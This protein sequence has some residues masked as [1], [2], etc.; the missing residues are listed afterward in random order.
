MLSFNPSAGFHQINNSIRDFITNIDPICQTPQSKITNLFH[1][2]WIPMGICSA[3]ILTGTSYLCSPD[4]G[5]TYVV[6]NIIGCSAAAV[7]PLLVSI[8]LCTLGHDALARKNPPNIDQIINDIEFKHEDFKKIVS[9]QFVRNGGADGRLP[10]CMIS[11]IENKIALEKFL[12]LTHNYQSLRDNFHRDNFHNGYLLKKFES[13]LCFMAKNDKLFFQSNFRFLT[14]NKQFSQLTIEYLLIF[15]ENPDCDTELICKINKLC[16]YAD[17]S[18]SMRYAKEL[19]K[20]SN[21][22]SCESTKRFLRLCLPLL[23]NCCLHDIEKYKLDTNLIEEFS[24][25]EETIHTILS[26]QEYKE[27]LDNEPDELQDWIYL[28]LQTSLKEAAIESTHLHA[29]VK[30]VPTKRALP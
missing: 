8:G 13:A 28:Y 1:K 4:T 30:K 27:F 23:Y 19:I 16:R 21:E 17:C 22:I 10:A 3:A 11:L 2:Y 20:I 14:K 18:T 26:S 6:T 25:F 15:A 24:E 7:S 29:K 5:L 9:L 12:S